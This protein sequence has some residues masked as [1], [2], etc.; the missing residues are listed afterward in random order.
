MDMTYESQIND[1]IFPVALTL[2][3][4]SARKDLTHIERLAWAAWD[5]GACGRPVNGKHVAFTQTQKTVLRA[6]NRKVRNS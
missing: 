3:F 5:T 1:G 2:E 6:I 4:V